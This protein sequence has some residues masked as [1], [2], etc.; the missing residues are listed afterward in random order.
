MRRAVA[1]LRNL[2]G[3]AD[4]ERDLEAE[5]RAYLDFAIDQHMR[6][7]LSRE[8]AERAARLESGGLEQVKESVR[9]VRAGAAIES[10]WRDVTFG[11]RVLRRTPGFSA[12]AVLTIALGVGV[13]ASIFAIVNG[14]AFHQLPLADGDRILSL[15]QQ[16][17][18]RVRRN[19]HGMSSFFWYTEYQAYRDRN[20]TLAGLAA[21]E[22]LV[23]ASLGAGEPREVIG[24][25]ASCNYFDVLGMRPPVGRG[26]SPG[27]CRLPGAPAEVVLSD[28]LWRQAFAGDRAI[29]GRTVSLNRAPFVVVGIAPPGFGGTEPVPAT[30]WVPLTMQQALQP[31]RQLLG[32]AHMS[33]IAL[34]GRLA[35]GTSLGQA[36]AD[37][38]LIAGQI[39]QL[40]PARRTRLNLSVASLLPQ[41]EEQTLVLGVGGILL[42]AVSL[43]LLVACA[44][45][46]SLLLARTASRT[47]ELAL[48]LAL[49]AGR[50]QLM[51]Q[52]L[53]ESLI[54]AGL[55][56]AAGWVLSVWSSTALVN[57]VLAHLPPGTP[58]LLL[59]IGTDLRVFLY[60]AGMTLLAG[61]AVGL[62]PAL[63]ASRLGLVAALKQQDGLGPS[64]RTARSGFLRQALVAAQVAASMVLL[65][66]AG[67]LMHGLART[68]R[69]D[70]GLNL[71][72]VAVMSFDLEN[73]GYDQARA[74]AFNRD[75]LDRL[76]ALPGVNRVAL[77]ETTPLSD[78]HSQT[79]FSLPGRLQRS[80]EMNYVSPS[81]FETFGLTIARG[82]TFTEDEVRNDAHVVVVTQAV[83]RRFWPDADPLGKVLDEGEGA[84][85]TSLVVV[86]VAR[87]AQVSHLGEASP[88]Y[89]Y[90]PASAPTQTHL[91]VVGTLRRRVRG[92]GPRDAR[93]GAETRPG[94]PGVHPARG[95]HPRSLARAG[96]AG[97]DRRRHARRP[98]SRTGRPRSLRT[99]R[100]QRDPAGRRNRHP[101][102]TRCRQAR[103]DEAGRRPSRAT[104]GPGSRGR[105]GGRR[106]GRAAPHQ[107]PVR[108]E[109]AR[110]RRVRR[111]SGVPARRG[112]GRRLRASAAGAQRGPDGR[113]A[114]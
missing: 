89:L 5:V 68:Y 64:A 28:D 85:V 75:L 59:P 25:L 57:A 2:F 48:R 74:V 51:R 80:V 9:A 39:D 56:G 49:G 96:A 6:R 19:V 77:A 34:L 29:L 102:S 31:S 66:S 70:P 50:W 65:L 41:L 114:M 110:P 38:R 15:T 46:A 90:L 69:I 109:S 78:N 10:I 86:G 44:N 91:A 4:A 84:N 94:S 24:A 106:R 58:Q 17:E 1:A 36:R 93:G 101:D 33:W 111:R 61:V 11:V 12:A 76:G 27:E 108:P 67:L 21:Y 105:P 55:G 88:V 37:L 113:A 23:T 42:L 3:R 7:G 103:R 53:I 92:A 60:T 54:L 26:F 100:L 43:V 52:L 95:G 87:D 112:A 30:F 72:N 16:L 13:N 71:S 20:H 81:Y 18:G 82:R 14:L 47:R 104:G 79:T 62:A 45:V 32:D 35:P 8:E 97:S 98:R 22:P 73:G 40:E 99:G 63:G 83:A 107:A